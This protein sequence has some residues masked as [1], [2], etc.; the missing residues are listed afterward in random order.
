[1]ALPVAS[2]LLNL[3][4][5]V[6]PEILSLRT[7]IPVLALNKYLSGAVRLPNY[8]RELLNSLWREVSYT[9]ARYYGMNPVQARRV[10]DLSSTKQEQIIS[11]YKE[12]A[13]RL[14][15]KYEVDIEDIYNGMSM[16][17]KAPEEM[18][19]S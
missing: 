6:K 5:F 1:M 12:T 18:D 4:K 9:R 2:A 8:R 10:R 15:E 11:I 16:S 7:N 13:Q 17:D 19:L 3:V 14:A